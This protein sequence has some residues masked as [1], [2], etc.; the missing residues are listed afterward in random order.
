MRTYEENL[1]NFIGQEVQIYMVHKI[2]GVQKG[3]IRC[4]HPFCDENKIGFVYN[5]REI[6]MYR[7]EIESIEYE[8][9]KITINGE[10]QNIVI[11]RI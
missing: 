8:K 11:K 1:K 5:D 2:Y 6:F 10:L 3:K 7:D 9:N 4:F